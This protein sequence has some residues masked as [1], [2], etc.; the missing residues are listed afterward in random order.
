MNFV[1]CVVEILLELLC[2]IRLFVV[3]FIR[4]D[5]QRQTLQKHSTH[6]AAEGDFLKIFFFSI[7]NDKAW[8]LLLS[9]CHVGISSNFFLSPV[10]PSITVVF[11]PHLCIIMNH[12]IIML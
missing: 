6:A 2:D 7:E 4:G 3:Q 8:S 10:A 9:V 1:G 12:Y 11:D 5:A